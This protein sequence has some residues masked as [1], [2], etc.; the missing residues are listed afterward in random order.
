[1]VFVYILT[2]YAFLEVS[3]IIL[4]EKTFIKFYS[5]YIIMLHLYCISDEPF[6]LKY[7]PSRIFAFH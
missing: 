3:Y 7:M 2:L 1:M 4:N 6:N 5:L